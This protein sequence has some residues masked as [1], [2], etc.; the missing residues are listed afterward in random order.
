MLSVV[1]AIKRPSLPSLGSLPGLMPR[2]PALRAGSSKELAGRANTRWN[3]HDY[4]AL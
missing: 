1:G 4:V 3:F 2:S